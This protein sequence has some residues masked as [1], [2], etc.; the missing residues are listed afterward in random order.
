MAKRWVRG[1]VLWTLALL[2]VA[3]VLAVVAVTS[4]MD[5]QQ[6]CFFEYPSVACPDGQDWRVGLLTFAFFGVPVIWLVGAVAAIVGR[7]LARRQ[8]EARHPP[9]RR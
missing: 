5:A 8:R 1:V 4:L 7:V 3:I 9:R 2:V 6:R